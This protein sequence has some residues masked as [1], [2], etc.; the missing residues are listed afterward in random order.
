MPAAHSLHHGHEMAGIHVEITLLAQ[1]LL[2]LPF[3]LALIFYVSAVFFTNHRFRRWPLHRTV[4]W[5][6]GVGCALVA[7]IGP[8]AEKSHHDFAAHMTGHLF[9]GMLAPLLMVLAAPMTLALRSMSV[10][11][12]RALSRVLKSRPAR[13]VSDPVVAT[14][15]NIGGLWLLYT[16]NLFNA[17]HDSLLL[18]LFIHLHV[19][20]A[21]YLFT[22]AI[23]SIDP[24]PHQASV[25]Y[26]AVV[27]LLALAAHGI[28]AKYL[29]AYPPEGVPPAE[30]E[31]GAMLMYYG[32]DLIDAVLIFLFCAQVYRATRPRAAVVESAY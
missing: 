1:L 14:L 24:A 32:G 17:M 15:L 3:V 28:L 23:I 13:F 4:L 20:I 9:L 31:A 10:P 16:T 8:L 5:I 12:A 18:H 22:A 26:R 21:G 7:V 11:W 6:A 25:R 2:A 30:A 29:Y 27:L 19:F